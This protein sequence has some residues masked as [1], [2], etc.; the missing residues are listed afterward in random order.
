MEDEIYS[1]IID[2][3][4]VDGEDNIDIVDD[5]ELSTTRSVELIADRA[6][7]DDGSETYNRQQS[8]G[9][10]TPANVSIIGVGGVGCWAALYFA[11]IGTKQIQLIDNDKVDVTNLNRTMFK[12][13]QVGQF[14]T[15][16][17]KELILERRPN[18][19][20]MSFT[21]KYEELPSTIQKNIVNSIVIDCRDSIKPLKDIKSP[22]IGGYN[23]LNATIHVS[24]NLKHVFGEEESPYT[25]IPSYVIV[26][27]IIAGMIT[28]HVCVEDK[29]GVSVEKIM[30]IDFKNF[31]KVFDKKPARKRVTKKKVEAI[32]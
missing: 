23:G 24:P 26:P 16:A 13:S 1:D 11:L 12:T 5:T 18:C 17:M 9:I 29:K 27:T 25:I 7:M 20:V 10:N 14:K 30:N 8:L 6:L 2:D 3:E 19:N 28:N 21:R 31:L 22:I 4:H 32:E 15:I